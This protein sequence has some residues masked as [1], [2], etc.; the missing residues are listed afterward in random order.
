MD[1][2][3]SCSTLMV[4]FTS[5]S[6]VINSR[7]Y[8]WGGGSY[9][10]VLLSGR[11]SSVHLKSFKFGKSLGNDSIES[12]SSLKSLTVRFSTRRPNLWF[13]S[14]KSIA[15]LKSLVLLI[16]RHLYRIFS[17]IMVR[18]FLHARILSSL[19]FTLRF[20]KI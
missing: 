10:I 17:V 6:H 5:F 18:Y 1:A 19:S 16:F 9:R 7:W 3:G 11:G 12:I 20:E 15:L 4:T 8:T 13:L 14:N 2:N